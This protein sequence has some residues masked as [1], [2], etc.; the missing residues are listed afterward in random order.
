M[1]EQKKQ[2]YPVKA[3]RDNFKLPLIKQRKGASRIRFI[4]KDIKRINLS[5]IMTTAEAF[6]C[7]SNSPRPTV[8][9]AT[10]PLKWKMLENLQTSCLSREE[11]TEEAERVSN[12]PD[13]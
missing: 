5:R 7:E 9:S 12:S 4:T 2:V 13:Y 3:S 11:N 8:F 10:L 6:T 1:G